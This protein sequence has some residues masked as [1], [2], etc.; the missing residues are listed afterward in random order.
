MPGLRALRHLHKIANHNM[1]ARARWALLLT[2]VRL[3]VTQIALVKLLRRNLRSTRVFGFRVE[4]FDYNSFLSQFEE[5]FVNRPYYFAHRGEA[6]QIID[7]GSNIG[8]SVLYFKHLYPRARVAA[9]EPDPSTFRLLEQNVQNNELHDVKLHNAAVSDRSG[10]IEFYNDPSNPGSLLMSTV[11]A[12]MP[13][14]PQMVSAVRLSAYITSAVDYLK[15]DVEGA[16]SAVM[17]EL[18]DAAAL[19]F[20]RHMAI[21]YHHHIEPQDDQLSGLLRT[22]EENGC[23]YDIAGSPGESLDGSEDLLIRVQQREASFQQHSQ[24][25]IAAQPQGNQ[26]SLPK[27]MI[28]ESVSGVVPR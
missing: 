27:T 24:P 6:P 17:R 15:L 23:T 1:P 14:Q 3:K 12:R 20:I 18:S 10:E 2:Y 26:I 5:I 9:F 4:F 7:C 22:L 13:T 8:M 25:E 19:A 21:E 11:R 28:P 16:E